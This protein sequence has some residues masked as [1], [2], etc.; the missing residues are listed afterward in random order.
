MVL[1]GSEQRVLPRFTPINDSLGHQAGDQVLTE[2][3]QRLEEAI[4]SGDTVTRMGCDEF[5]VLL[6]DL[7]CEED[8]L[9]VAGRILEVIA[10]PLDV[11]GIS[12]RLTASIG[13]TLSEGK[14][15]DPQQ[16]IQETDLA[17]Y[18]AKQQG[19]NDYQWQ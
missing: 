7:A 9:A 1:G 19:R 3:T 18:K 12:V 16:L 14:L 10:R 2:V 8:V 17:M 5:I 6:P 4:G 15:K 13:I 11:N